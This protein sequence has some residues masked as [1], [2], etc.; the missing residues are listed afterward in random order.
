VTGLRATEKVKVKVKVRVREKL[1][2][3]RLRV[4]LPVAVVD[5]VRSSNLRSRPFSVAPAS[6]S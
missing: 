2:M 6:V 4:S 3:A 5:G 1:A